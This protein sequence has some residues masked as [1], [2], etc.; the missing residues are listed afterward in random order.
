MKRLNGKSMVLWILTV[1]LCVTT[2]GP[3]FASAGDRTLYY[4]DGDSNG[5][6]Q[7]AVQTENGFLVITSESMNTTVKRYT[8]PA[9]EPETFVLEYTFGQNGTNEAEE[10]KETEADKAVAEKEEEEE[11]E[12]EEA[13]SGSIS[14]TR[15][16]ISSLCSA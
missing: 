8:D 6:V 14:R 15:F 1:I 12:P 13:A 3:A 10:A 4:V 11:E 16:S 9:G 7:G 2:C 5:Y